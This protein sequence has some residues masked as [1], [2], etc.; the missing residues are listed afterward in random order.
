MEILVICQDF[1]KLVK[2]YFLS[3]DTNSDNESDDKPEYL[4]DSWEEE[5]K[6]RS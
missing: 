6:L 5:K 4:N 1:R 3:D 2:M